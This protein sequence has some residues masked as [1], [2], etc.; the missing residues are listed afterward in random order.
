[1][2][3]AR[4]PARGREEGLGRRRDLVLLA[5]GP[6]RRGRKRGV[7]PQERKKVSYL[8]KMIMREIPKD[9]K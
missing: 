8:A 7:S 5:A 6:T 4:G 9:L 3:R 1:M 2:G